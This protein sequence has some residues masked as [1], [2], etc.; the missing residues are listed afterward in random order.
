M[1]NPMLM[2]R[3]PSHPR[4]MILPFGRNGLESAYSKKKMV[5]SIAATS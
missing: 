5:K 1:T 4:F 3:L 2:K